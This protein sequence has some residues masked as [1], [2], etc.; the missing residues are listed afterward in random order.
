[1]GLFLSLIPCFVEY[2]HKVFRTKVVKVEKKQQRRLMLDAYRA[3]EVCNQ[4]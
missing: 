2:K 3:Y 1:M 4:H